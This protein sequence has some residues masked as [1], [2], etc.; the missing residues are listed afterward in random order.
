MRVPILVALLAYSSF[1]LASVA[2]KFLFA[3]QFVNGISFFVAFKACDSTDGA[4]DGY[5]EH[6]ACICTDVNS[7]R[8]QTCGNCVISSPNATKVEVARA[9]VTVRAFVDDC[10]RN[11]D[12]VANITLTSFA[13]LPITSA[14]FTTGSPN[15]TTTRITTSD[16][17]TIQ[18]GTITDTITDTSTSST[19]SGPSTPTVDPSSGTGIIPGP[20]G[21]TG[22]R[23]WASSSL[24]FIVPL[25][26]L[27]SALEGL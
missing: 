23:I 22:M 9:Y 13:P 8:L 20:T 15:A 6:A 19:S 4:L 24:L 5:V 18:T 26:L 7:A 14:S 21:S 12:P 3:R 11:G 16:S 25:M 1:A 2:S 17:V 27:G 10:K